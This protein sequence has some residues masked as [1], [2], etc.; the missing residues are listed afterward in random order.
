MNLEYM[1]KTC[2]LQGKRAIITGASS[3]IGRA[4][5]QSMAALGAH[6]MLT[7]RRRDKLEAAVAKIHC[8]GGSAEYAVL[9]QSCEKEI[10]SFF[11]EY[12]Q[13]FGNPEMVVVNAGIN[14]QQTLM[15]AEYTA[16][17]TILRT[18]LLGS[19]FMLQ[20]AAQLMKKQ[21][22][23]SITIVT[24]IN[25]VQAVYQ[26]AA[27]SAIKAALENLVRSAAIE[28]AEFGI[29]VNAMAP[30]ATITGM[31]DLPGDPEKHARFDR[32]V[33]LGYVAYPEEMGDVLALMHSD[34]FRYM[35]GSTVT[36]DGGLLLRKSIF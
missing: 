34:A 31:S 14:L 17:E 36:V 5:A 27:Y 22:G 8:D 26:E 19:M 21:H 1:M 35:T 30:G 9:D 6:V 25:A 7:G 29:R 24:S 4:C 2:G 33:P 15:Q 16:T 11:K 3:G 32:A 10:E 28:L 18:N 23:G 13:L 20:Q 12:E